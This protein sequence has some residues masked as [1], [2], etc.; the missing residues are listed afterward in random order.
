VLSA[1]DE[2]DEVETERT[3]V[4]LLIEV[5]VVLHPSA[6]PFTVLERDPQLRCGTNPQLGTFADGGARHSQGIRT[7][8]CRT[9]NHQIQAEPRSC[10]SLVVHRLLHFV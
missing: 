7:S 4:L 2:S 8:L 10:G 5:L 9:R 3:L 6:M 1:D